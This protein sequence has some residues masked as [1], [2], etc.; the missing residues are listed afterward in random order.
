MEAYDPAA[1]FSSIDS[2][3]PLRLRQ[4][5]EHRAVEPGAPR[6][7]AAAADRRRRRRSAVA[8]RRREVID[9]FPA[10]YRARTGSRAQRAKLG[11]GARGADDGA[12]ARSPTTGSRCCTPHASTSRSPG[13]AS[14][15]A[16]AGDERAACARCSRDR[17]RPTPGWRAGASAARARTKAR[18]RRATPRGARRAHAPRQPAGSSRATIASRKRSPPRPTTATS[19]PFERLLEA[20]RRPFDETRRQD[21]RYAEP[22]PARGHGQLPDVLRHLSG[23]R[24]RAPSS[25]RMRQSPL[26]TRRADGRVSMRTTREPPRP[27]PTGS[28]PARSSNAC[29]ARSIA[30]R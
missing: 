20:L 18:A 7:D 14:A 22:A 10:L 30:S 19:A 8:R 28:A 5:A 16:A 24:R 21:A 27:V 1:V 12:D 9:A 17:R 2:A 13:G 15:D 26:F 11:L 29:R 25:T 3:R 23:R 4:P 6:R